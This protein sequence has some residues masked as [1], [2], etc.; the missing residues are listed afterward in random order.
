VCLLT[1]SLSY[2]RAHQVV[3]AIQEDACSV[4]V[5]VHET[6]ERISR[7]DVKRI[8]SWSAIEVGDIVKVK[9][10]GSKLYYEANVVSRNDDGTFKVKFGDDEIEDD[11]SIDRMIKLM[12]GRLEHKEWMIYKEE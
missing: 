9:E 3:T 5:S 6:L 10:D 7:N 8:A 12:T 11:V 2:G 4:Q 1:V